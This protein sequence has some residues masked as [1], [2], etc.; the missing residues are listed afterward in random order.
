MRDAK[1]PESQI[2]HAV[3]LCIDMQNIFAP[4]GLWE[5]PWMEKVL[6]TVAAIVSRHQD[7]T[8]FT[9]FIT[10]LNPEDRPGQWQVYF[11]RWRQANRLQLPPSALDLVPALAQ[12]RSSRPRRRQTGLCRI[13]QSAPCRHAGREEHRDRGDN[14]CGDRRLR[15]LDGPERRRSRLQDCR[16]RR[17]VQLVGRRPRCAHDDVSHALP[18]SGRPRDRGRARGVLAGIGV[19][20][21]PGR[22]PGQRRFAVLVCRL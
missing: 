11:Q 22:A 14:G 9:R 2:R 1:T 17:V 19:R 5:T 13:Q 7:R 18:R 3:H 15:S 12:L 16:R 21:L 20:S 6:P 4:G 10:P 8:I